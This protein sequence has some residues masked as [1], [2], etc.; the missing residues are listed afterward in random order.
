MRK[1]ILIV[2][3][4]QPILNIIASTLGVI[5]FNTSSFLKP[6]DVL[7]VVSGEKNLRIDLLITDIVMPGMSGVELAIELRKIMP[8]LKVV[9]ISGNFRENIF[10]DKVSG[11]ISL[12]KPFSLSDLKLVVRESLQMG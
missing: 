8:G 5:H 6:E 11:D 3:D 4:Q 1:N 2:D 12:R 9:Y 10:R 7:E